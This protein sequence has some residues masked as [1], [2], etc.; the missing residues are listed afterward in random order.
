MKLSTKSRYGLR[1]MLALA[2]EY[3]QNLVQLKD[4][5]KREDLPEKYLEQIIISLKAANLVKSVR[6]A[7]GGYYLSKTP[8]K[9]TLREIVEKLEGPLSLVDC[10]E[11][12]AIC[13][14]AGICPTRTIWQELGDLL[15]NKL[16]S[17][18]L[19]TLMSISEKKTK[20]K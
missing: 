9:V 16:E 6:G 5:A 17:M 1:V 13:N 8:E 7:K 3:K 12:D 2:K 4:I 18:T 20:S 11:D 19:V 15:V 14:R 10:V